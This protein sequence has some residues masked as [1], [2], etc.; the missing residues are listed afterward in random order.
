LPLR[1]VLNTGHA[2][3]PLSTWDLYE[4]GNIFSQQQ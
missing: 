2:R 4:C 3:N 1:R